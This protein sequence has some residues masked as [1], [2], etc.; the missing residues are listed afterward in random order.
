MTRPKTAVPPMR[1][2]RRHL[3]TTTGKGPI[4]M[5]I[6]QI[7]QSELTA[8]ERE[9]L[10][11]DEERWRRIGGGAHLNE[12]LEFYPGLDIRRRMAMRLN[13]MNKPEGRGYAETL[14]ELYVEAGF[15]SAVRPNETDE[16][17]KDRSRTMTSFTA[18]LWLND[19]AERITTLRNILAKMSPGERSRLN[20][21]ISARQRV[22]KALK[23]SGDGAE[24]KPGGS[25]L[26]ALKDQLAASEREIAELKAKLARHDSGSLFDLK[27]DSVGNIVE[28]I[29]GNVSDY[30]ADA[31][32]KALVE[33]V[34]KKKQRPAG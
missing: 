23:A 4:A 15:I 31:I 26:R 12:W 18:V 25:P 6:E 1:Q 10:K 5:T 28:A 34:K 16:V 2:H 20:S 24:G 33:R 30:K 27:S 11:R 32:G 19:D 7:K 21:P 3:T 29:V 17:R 22:E 13:H 8:N 9:V 14:H